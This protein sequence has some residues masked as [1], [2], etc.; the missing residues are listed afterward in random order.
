MLVSV[1]LMTVVHQVTS[2]ALSD[3]DARVRELETALYCPSGFTYVRASNSCYKVN[4]ESVPW[5][6]ASKH[7]ASLSTGA[8]L[9]FILNSDQ[10]AGINAFMDSLDYSTAGV[11]PCCRFFIGGQRRIST[12]CSTKLNFVWKSETA[13][14]V[15]LTYTHWLGEEPNCGGGNEGCLELYAKECG[16]KPGHN[17]ND[18]NCSYNY[19]SICEASP[20]ASPSPS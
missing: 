7:C 3:C 5:A 12:D 10:E 14:P 15:A 1:I 4:K 9:A 16:T 18:I 6:D 19:C 20:R 11:S 8:H 2:D 17:W 13:E